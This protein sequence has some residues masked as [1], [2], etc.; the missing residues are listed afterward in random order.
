MIV[1]I[2]GKRR[3][4]I[5]VNGVGTQMHNTIGVLVLELFRH[6]HSGTSVDDHFSVSAWFTM[7]RSSKLQLPRFREKSSQVNPQ[8][9]EKTSH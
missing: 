1:C 6:G 4:Q 8:R 2:Y 5:G 9:L 7:K 3:A